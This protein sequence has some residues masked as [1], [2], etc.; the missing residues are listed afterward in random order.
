MNPAP[1]KATLATA[2]Q[3]KSISGPYLDSHRLH[4]AGVRLSLTSRS[5]QLSSLA[6]SSISIC[7]VAPKGAIKLFHPLFDSHALADL[8]WLNH[9]STTDT[10]GDQP[11]TITKVQERGIHSKETHKPRL[12]KKEALTRTKVFSFCMGSSRLY[13]ITQT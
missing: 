4:S 10:I 2:A 11:C 6:S 13:F 12:D 1:V 5:L 7:S 9:T 8:H 3:A